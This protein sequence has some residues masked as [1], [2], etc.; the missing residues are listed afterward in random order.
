METVTTFRL[1]T[2]SQLSFLCLF[3]APHQTT[4]YHQYVKLDKVAH[5]VS[6]FE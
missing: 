6:I 3:Y 1:V 4:L 5:E 2:P